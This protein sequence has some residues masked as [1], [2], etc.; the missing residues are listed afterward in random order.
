MKHK[1]IFPALLALLSL[2]ACSQSTTSDKPKES[3]KN[4]IVGTFNIDAKVQRDTDKQ[5]QYMANNKVDIFGIQ[6]VNYNNKRFADKGVTTYNPLPDFK[7]APYKHDYYGN[8]IDFAGG[9]YGIATVSALAL[10]DETTTKLAETEQAQKFSKEFETVY[11]AY[12]PTKEDTVKAMDAMWDDEGIANKGAME[13]RVYTRVVF[14]KDGKEIAFY[15]THMSYETKEIRK[16]QMEQLQTAMKNDPVKYTIAVGDFN[17]DQSTKEFDLYRK[18]FNMANGGKGIWYDTF[19][20]E[21]DT[22]N[23]N[24]IDN[25]IVSKNIEIKSVKYEKVDLSDHLP[26]IAELTLK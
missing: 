16:K 9:G 7:K 26:L 21:D 15:N 19:T 18:N 17:A 2:T 3:D 6:E 5:R 4:L 12:D 25:I 8:A 20:E 22:M 13:P 23:I 24:S 14:K 10:S 1:L 11:K